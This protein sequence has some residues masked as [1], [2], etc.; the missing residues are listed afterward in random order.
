LELSGGR[1]G[2]KKPGTSRHKYGEGEGVE[3]PNEAKARKNPIRKQM[4]P[5]K[6]KTLRANGES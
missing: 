4:K 5:F 1:K 6:L 2:E 3:N